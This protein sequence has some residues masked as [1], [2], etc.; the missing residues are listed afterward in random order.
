MITIE[1]SKRIAKAAQK[2]NNIEDLLLWVNDECEFC[3]ITGERFSYAIELAKKY[4]KKFHKNAIKI[5][6]EKIDDGQRFFNV[7]E[8]KGQKEDGDVIVLHFYLSEEKAEKG[9]DFY[10]DMYKTL[11][12]RK[13]MVWAD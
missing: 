1:L 7:Y 11:W 2:Y 3:E 5:E 10:K 12:V 4:H 13:R 6:T 8:L 9:K